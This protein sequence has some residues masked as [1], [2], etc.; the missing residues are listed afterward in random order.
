MSKN[1]MYEIIQELGKIETNDVEEIIDI[2]INIKKKY[3]N[4]ILDLIKK[5]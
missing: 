2:A 3:K 5:K 4:K 1:D